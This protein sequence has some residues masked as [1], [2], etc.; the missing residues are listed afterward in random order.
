MGKLIPK[1]AFCCV[2][3]CVSSRL[4]KVVPGGH[5]QRLQ[6]RRWQMKPEGCWS[7]PALLGKGRPPLPGDQTRQLI[8]H[9]TELPEEKTKY[10]VSPLRK[11]FKNRSQSPFR[12]KS[13]VGKHTQCRE[14]KGRVRESR[15]KRTPPPIAVRWWLFLRKRRH[16]SNVKAS[17]KFQV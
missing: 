14:Q 11:S 8:C 6:G 5:W 2:W 15:F 16:D 4:Q 7:Q 9:V 10:H 3:K 12:A 17:R 13:N 1:Q